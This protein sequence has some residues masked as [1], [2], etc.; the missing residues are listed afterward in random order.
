MGWTD[1]SLYPYIGWVVVRNLYLERQQH[2]VDMDIQYNNGSDMGTRV[3]WICC[4]LLN[5]Q[6]LSQCNEIL[7]S[8]L[9]FW[10]CQQMQCERLINRYLRPVSTFVTCLWV[11]KACYWN[12]EWKCG[13]NMSMTTDFFYECQDINICNTPSIIYRVAIGIFDNVINK[14]VGLTVVEYYLKCVL[15][16]TLVV[17][18]SACFFYLFK[19]ECR[20]NGPL[21]GCHCLF[22]LLHCLLG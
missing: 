21:Y 13:T 22:L 12:A 1:S 20:E 14:S 10:N 6:H 9:Q 15:S 18:Y 17:H 7:L 16:F 5:S 19:L 4:N 2:V 3:S 11:S 8:Y